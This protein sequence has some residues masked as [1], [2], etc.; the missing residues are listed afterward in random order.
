M[1][2]DGARWEAVRDWWY[3]AL[4]ALRE[5]EDPARLEHAEK[6]VGRSYDAAFYAAKAP[7]TSRGTHVRKHA[8]VLRPIGEHW[9]RPGPLAAERGRA[10]HDLM[11]APLV[12][13][14][15][16]RASFAPG[17]VVG[18]VEKARHFVSEAG[19][20]LRG[21]GWLDEGLEAPDDDEPQSC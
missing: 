12:A 13:D 16:P 11:R 4:A 5:G 9:V 14:Y 19:A 10:L 1:S 17:A 20:V 8:G 18:Y 21:K 15:G 7:P 3:R 6:A 2:R